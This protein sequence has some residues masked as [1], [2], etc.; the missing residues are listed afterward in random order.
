[1]KFKYC[2]K[3][4][5]LLCLSVFI[6]ACATRPDEDTSIRTIVPIDAVDTTR[7]V[8]VPQQW[9]QD[10]NHSIIAFSAGGADGAFGAGVIAGWTQKGN[11]PEFDVVTG[12]S[13]GGLLAVLTFLGPQYDALA[14]ELYTNQTNDKIFK[15]R[16]LNGIFSDSLYDNTPLKSQIEKY[17]DAG[18]LAKIAREHEKGRRLYIATTN[19]DAGQLVIWDMGKIAMGGRTNPVQH[20]Q[21]V[22]RASAAVPGFFPPVYIKPQKGVQLRQAHVDGGVK[23]PI[24]YSTFMGRSSAR[25]KDLYIIVNGT[26]KRFNDSNPVQPNLAS[27]AQKTIFELM[28]ELQSDTIFR[29]YSRVKNSGVKF[30]LTSIPDDVPVSDKSLDFDPQRMQALY[31]AGFSLGLQGPENWETKPPSVLR[32]ANAE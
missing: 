17:V 1:M 13:T 15:N 25:Q 4:I 9:S 18:M 30:H 26:T 8:N 27:I 6:A 7:S 22:L 10:N 16:G 31:E 3:I 19:L 28:R 20:F 5:G 2:T 12:V 24:L 29:H 23:E 14:K 11:R 21:K 32:E